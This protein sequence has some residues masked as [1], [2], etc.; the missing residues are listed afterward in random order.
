[1]RR[2]INWQA[3]ALGAAA[4]VALATTAAF[5]DV[6]TKDDGVLSEAPRVLETLTSAPDD[7]I[8]DGLLRK[9]ECVLVFP[10]ITKGAFVV[11]G[12]Y[13]RGVATCRGGDGAMGPPAFFR[14]GGASIGWQIGGKQTDLVLL[15][16]N[17]DGMQHLLKHKFALGGE[18]SVAAGPVGRTAKADTDAHL[19]AQILSWSRSQGVFAG[20]SL[21]GAVVREDEEANARVYG[22]EV[23]AKDVLTG[24]SVR[25][26]KQA[27]RFVNVARKVTAQAELGSN[28]SR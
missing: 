19:K 18:A 21:E 7:A 9:A 15:V 13:G 2:R 3:M 16:L 22:K 11:G 4:S 26:P 8:P 20:A 5:A 1:M 17:K 24:G 6:D 10:S 12:T 28:H 14:L 23:H 25:T 27:Q